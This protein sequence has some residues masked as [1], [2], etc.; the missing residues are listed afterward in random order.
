MNALKKSASLG[1]IVCT[2]SAGVA[3]L[4]VLVMLMEGYYLY[5]DVTKIVCFMELAGIALVAV[6]FLMKFFD[7]K[8]FFH[9][10]VVATAAVSVIAIVIRLSELSMMPYG[11]VLHNSATF[12]YLHYVFLL[13]AAVDFF[14]NGI[15]SAGVA[16]TLGFIYNNAITISINNS[17]A[18]GYTDYFYRAEAT[19]IF[20]A[21]IM[22]SVYVLCSAASKHVD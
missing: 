19:F 9:L 3:F 22:I 6:G 16:A 13:G 10:V 15:I 17:M 1:F 14:K 4:G 12:D 20:D 11:M 8:D 7:S 2:I 18:Y 5:T 21:L